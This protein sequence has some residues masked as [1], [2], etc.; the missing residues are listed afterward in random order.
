L[1][2]E[3]IESSE[4]PPL[5]NDEANTDPENTLDVDVDVDVDALSFPVRMTLRMKW[6]RIQTFPMI[7]NPMQVQEAVFSTK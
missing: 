4:L 1:E 6:Y 2:K 3:Q 5:S 7:L